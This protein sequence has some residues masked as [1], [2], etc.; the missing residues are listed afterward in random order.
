MLATEYARHYDIEPQREGES[1][2]QFRQRVA[3]ELRDK[4]EL[5]LAH[6]AQRNERIEQSED[7][8]TG[9]LGAVAQAL[10]DVDY[11]VNGERQVG[12]DIAAGELV[13]H[14][15]PKMTPKMAMLAILLSEEE[16]R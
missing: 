8:M 13:R 9:V 6:E 11:N 1:D 14:P 2:T 16:G 4:G 7:V 10:Q 15:K 12:C 3:G 5:V